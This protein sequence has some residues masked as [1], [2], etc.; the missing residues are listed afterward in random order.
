V[1]PR[2]VRPDTVPQSSDAVR[3]APSPVAVAKDGLG[4]GDRAALLRPAG[5]QD[6]HRDPHQ[7][8]ATQ[9][10][11]VQLAL[12][13]AAMT[14]AKFFQFYCNIQCVLINSIISAN[15]IYYMYR[16]MTE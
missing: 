5:R 1:C 2:G 10:R 9:R 12:H 7:G 3:Q 14:A 15:N 13:V 8:H 11:I 16:K 4:T 6:A